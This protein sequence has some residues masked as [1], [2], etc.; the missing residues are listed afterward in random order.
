[1]RQTSHRYPTNIL[2]SLVY[3]CLNALHSRND[4]EIGG[5]IVLLFNILLIY[6]LYRA[7]LCEQHNSLNSF[8]FNFSVCALNSILLHHTL[9]SRS[10]TISTHTYKKKKTQKTGSVI[11]ICIYLNWSYSNKNIFSPS[12]CLVWISDD[13]KI[14]S[15]PLVLYRYSCLAESIVGQVR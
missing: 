9:S 13:Y 6:I 15:T 1:M 8:L 4:N 7:P 11:H 12:A 3:L 10:M 14:H 2:N 5:F